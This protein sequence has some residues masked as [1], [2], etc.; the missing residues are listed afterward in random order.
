MGA[1]YSVSGEHMGLDTQSLLLGLA[2]IL[3]VAVLLG[4]A[5]QLI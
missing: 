1:H 4:D 3:A 5:L 2:L